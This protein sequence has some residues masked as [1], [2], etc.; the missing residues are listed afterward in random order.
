MLLR[1]VPEMIRSYGGIPIMVKVG[2]TN[3]KHYMREYNAVFA[4]DHSGHYY[5]AE[6]SNTE[7][8]MI[9]LFR[10]LNYLST[11]ESTFAQLVAPLRAEYAK[12][13]ETNFEVENAKSVVD[14]LRSFYSKEARS[15]SN[16]DG[17]RIDC[18]DWW[19]NVRSSNTEPLLRLN[20][21]ARNADVLHQK[22]E[23]LKNHIVG[24]TSK[25]LFA[26]ERALARG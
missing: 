13:E 14:H 25:I 17:V 1:S 16:I 15:V 23:E 20:L 12:I 5:N 19:F 4:G 7:N 22:F 21:E 11:K 9:I 24:E 10:L 2:H 18:D 6:Q 26:P 3:F 8:T